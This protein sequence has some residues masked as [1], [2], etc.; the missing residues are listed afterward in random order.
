MLTETES[1]T[2]LLAAWRSG[3]VDSGNRLFAI[4]YGHLRRLAAAQLRHETPDH[5]LQP[6]A[7]VNE[8]Y[9][10]LFA[11]EPVNCQDRAH[12]LAIAAENLRRILIEH[13]RKRRRLRRGGS[14]VQVT[15]SDSIP[16]A[17]DSQ[18]FSV[19]F[20]ELEDALQELAAIDPRV[21]R[22]I[23]LR[24]FAGL[25]EKEAAEVLEISLTTLKR[26]WIYG[27]AWLHKHLHH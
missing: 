2:V 14:R 8:L 12:F 7:L 17:N 21:S 13:G 26:D 27:R 3:D 4:S 10:R 6:T 19:D 16:A 25:T 20:I 22:V 24:F 1:P 15:L 9:I 5:T 11:S 18:E 23:Q